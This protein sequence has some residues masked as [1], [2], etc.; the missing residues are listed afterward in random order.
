MHDHAGNTSTWS[1]NCS[2]CNRLAMS[3]MPHQRPSCS[4]CRAPPA[5][6]DR[7]QPGRSPRAANVR[8]LRRTAMPSILGGRATCSARGCRTDH[9]HQSLPLASTSTPCVNHH[10]LC[11]PPHLV[12]TTTATAPT[13]AV[14]LPI[15]RLYGHRMSRIEIASS[16]SSSHVDA[17]TP[18]GWLPC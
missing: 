14:P 17:S 11:Q 9:S 18:P 4:T 6:I 2:L 13:V 12:P 15:T 5:G 10:I 3:P 16:S 1:S 7:L 8:R